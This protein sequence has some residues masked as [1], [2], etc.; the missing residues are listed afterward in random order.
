MADAAAFPGA[1]GSARRGDRSDLERQ[2]YERVSF[3]HGYWDGVEREFRGFGMVEHLDTESFAD[4]HATSAH[5]PET[6]FDPVPEKHFSPPLLTKTSFHQG[7]VDDDTGD[8]HELDWAADYWPGDPDALA[9]TDGVNAFLRTLALPRHR[10]DA[11][12]TLR[13]STLRTKLYALDGTELQDRPFTVTE[14]A[15]GLREESPPVG[16]D[17]NRLR[18]FFPHPLAQR[19]TQWERGNEPM[20]QFLHRQLRRLRTAA[21]EGG[22]GPAAVPGLSDSRALRGAVP[23]NARGN[24]VCPTRRCRTVYGYSRLRECELR[25]ILNDGGPTVY[26]L[27][28]QVQAGTAARTLLGQSFN[29][30]DGEAFAGLPFGELGDFGAVMRTETLVLT[31]DILRDAFLD[32]ANPDAPDI[33]PYL[34]PESV[35]SWPAE[36][37]K[38]FQDG[39]PALAGYTFA[40]AQTI[41][42]AATS[43]KAR[44]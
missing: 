28:R 24:P 42:R 29:Y 8:W 21:A 31:E 16:D 38:E 39:M 10:R 20:T 13:G 27:Y 11:L 22:R 6:G 14:Q 12:R 37:P 43:P 40:D 33:P 32:P 9:H 17:Q 3:H 7:P 19:T 35:P 26:D 30:Y 4:Y 36:Y 15:Y 25:D 5:G 23:R 1:G 2:A 18:I 44:A 34:R 41:G